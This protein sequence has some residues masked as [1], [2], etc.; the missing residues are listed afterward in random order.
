MCYLAADFMNNLLGMVRGDIPDE[1]Y[2]DI[3]NSSAS[4]AHNVYQINKFLDRFKARKYIHTE[5]IGKIINLTIQITNKKSFGVGL[6]Y[7]MLLQGFMSDDSE[8]L[9]N[10]KTF[11]HE[12]REGMYGNN[13]VYKQ[14]SD[15]VYVE[16]LID[17]LLN[18]S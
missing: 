3:D 4:L 2:I 15:R 11:F 16:R 6:L 7:Y 17:R 1:Y 5:K 10:I 12:F 8:T 9:K 13:A 18:I 14:K